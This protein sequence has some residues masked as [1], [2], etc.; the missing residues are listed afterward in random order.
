M[1]SIGDIAKGLAELAKALKDLSR[2]LQTAF[3]AALF[4]VVA[5][6]AAV[7]EAAT[8]TADDG[9]SGNGDTEA[10]TTQ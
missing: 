3:L 9:A 8:D 10:V 4:F 6:A 1:A 7:G 2:S 5:T